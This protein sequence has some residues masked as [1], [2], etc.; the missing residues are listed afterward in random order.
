MWS[1]VYCSGVEEWCLPIT[2]VETINQSI[3]Q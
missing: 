1:H 3:N 2:E